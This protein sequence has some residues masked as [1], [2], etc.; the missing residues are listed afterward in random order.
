MD[1]LLNME[2]VTSV[3]N[4]KGYR[5]LYDDVK[6]QV[7]SLKALGVVPESYSSLLSSVLLNKLPQDLRLI[8]S[9]KVSDSE[10]NLDSL[11]KVVEEELTARERTV[12]NSSQPSARRGLD[13][14]PHTA[15]TLISGT[16]SITP[17]CCYC[18]Q[19]HPSK[20]CKIVT[21]PTA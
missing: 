18:A 14:S 15:T 17:L 19:H 21:Q 2:P 13:K 3:H 20:G 8:V 6:S 12:T 11:L 7:R 16:I 10:W 9:R 1:T 5:R 4:L